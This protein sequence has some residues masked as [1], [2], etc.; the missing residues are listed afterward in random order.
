MT[1]QVLEKQAESGSNF[2]ASPLSLHVMLSLIAAG[3]SGQTLQ[4]LLRFLGS[5]SVCDLNLLSSRTV[6]L[7]S[8][9]ENLA[10]GP[11]LSFVNGAWLEQSFTLK[12]TFQ[13]IVKGSYKAQL[14][15][16]D[17]VTKVLI[18]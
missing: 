14:K 8:A 17:F 5:K 9:N 3:S 13:G 16:V 10:G 12:S 11:L 7:A 6:S 1:N 18:L 15:S 2:V 4:Q